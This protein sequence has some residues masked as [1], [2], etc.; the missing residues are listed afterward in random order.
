[1]D[2]DFGAGT[3]SAV[4]L[5]QS[6][7]VDRLGKPLGVD[8][9]VGPGTWEALFGEETV[10]STAPIHQGDTLLARV[11][12]IARGE[13][14]VQEVPPYSNG[15]PR[16]E[17]Y[18]HSVGLGKGLSWCAAF[19]YWCYEQA[20]KELG[21]KNPLVKTAGCLDAWNRAPG[22]GAKRIPPSDP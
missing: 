4:K 18:L 21:V 22:A 6:R 9:V 7:S 5:F 12:E 2:G 15:G 16:V 11:V 19:V 13:I 3:E 10:P 20:A 14:G 1:I 17:E 8:G